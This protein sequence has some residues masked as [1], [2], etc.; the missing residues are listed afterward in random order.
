METGDLN[1]VLAVLRE[2]DRFVVTSHD[3]PDGDAIGSLLAMHL[4]LGALGKDSLMVMGG[5]API[6]DEYGF[7]ALERHGLLREAPADLTG[8]VLVAVDCAQESR[9]V[10]AT[11]LE[12]A[13][14]TVNI[15]HHHDNTRFGDVDLVVEDA[16]STGEVL[17]DVFSR[18][19]LELTPTSRRRSTRRS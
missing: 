15:D 13:P 17:A 6:P 9:I 2:H 3:N 7:L 16:S 14:L 12:G 1:A 19:G 4:A 18:L 10:A 11:L 5:P 8:R